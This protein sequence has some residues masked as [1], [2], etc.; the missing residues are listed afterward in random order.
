[1]RLTLPLSTL[2]VPRRSC[3]QSAVEK[4]DVS[5]NEN[6]NV[7]LSAYAHM[8]I[9]DCSKTSGISACMHVLRFGSAKPFHFPFRATRRAAPC[10]KASSCSAHWPA[11]P[12]GAESQLFSSLHPTSHSSRILHMMN[13]FQPV[14]ALGCVGKREQMDSTCV[15][16]CVCMYVCMFVCMYVCMYVCVCA[17][18]CVSV[19]VRGILQAGTWYS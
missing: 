7:E 9:R 18:P 8:H 10:S 3:Y 15:C 4:V 11:I 17:Y 14:M 16:V 2:Q 5:A 12:I 1:M 19:R 13:V 6:K